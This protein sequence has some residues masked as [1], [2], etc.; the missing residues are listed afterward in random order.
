[1]KTTEFL[2]F[3]GRNIVFLSKDGVYWIAI[4]PICE[5]LGVD[6]EAQRKAIHKHKTL[7][8]VPSNQTVHDASGRLQKM[9]CLP[10]KYIY[11]WIFSINSE[12]EGLI[13]YQLEC[14]N[15]LYNHFHGTIT[16]R[17][18]LLTRKVD[19]QTQIHNLKEELK[20]NRAYRE[21]AQLEKENKEVA[22]DLRNNDAELLEQPTLFR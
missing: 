17:K 4:K 22:K 21:L 16:G 11:G 19:I 15:I 3:N 20:E 14:Y 7:S 2:N 6:Y 13:Q 1:M 12:S 9:L 8:G 10:E 5:V 18:K